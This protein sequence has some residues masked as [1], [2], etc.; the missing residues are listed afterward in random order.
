MSLYKLT[1]I[2]GYM[3]FLLVLVYAVIG[4]RQ[5][6]KRK[7]L[8][9]V[10]KEIIVTGFFYIFILGMYALFEILKINYRPTLIDNILEVSYPS[11]HTM[12][13]VCLCS[14]TIILNKLKYS[15]IRFFK[16]ENIISIILMILIV[17]GRLFSGVHW[18]TDI[19]GGIIISSGM[20]F[21]YCTILN[22]VKER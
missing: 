1:E 2:L 10:D 11:S 16:I 22:M 4:I 3:A 13:A 5:L 6:I 8:L 15:K 18:F 20:L 9:K 21:I 7:S 12:L 19:L 14:S 17:F